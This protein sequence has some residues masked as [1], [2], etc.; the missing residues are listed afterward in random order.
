MK[1]GGIG[2]VGTGFVADRYM[3]SLET[4][5][6][7]RVVKAT[8][9]DHVRLAAFCKY[10]KVSGAR[11]LYELLVDGP[12]SPDLILNLTNPSAH[13]EVS[14]ACLEA[15]KHVYS[16]KPLATSMD[17]AH[18]LC[19]L[20]ER[21]GLMLASAP[22]SLLGEAAQTLWLA[23]RQNEI[24]TA[25]LVYAELDDD[26]VPHAPYKNWVSESGA[27]WPFRDEFSVGCTLE[28]AGYYL[29][30]L[31]AM[32]GTVEK[33]IAGSANL[34]ECKLGDGTPTAPD[35]SCAI[36]FFKSGIVARLT[37]SII[38]PHNHRIRIIGD[39]G[40]L[41]V[42]QSWDNEAA[43][44][45]RRRYVIRRRLINSPIARR[46]RIKGATHPKIKRWGAAALNF[47]LG[48]AEM[49]AALKESRPSRLSTGFSLHLN[50][51]TL[52]IQNASGVQIM[53][54]VCPP[55]EPMSWARTL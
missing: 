1:L 36:L 23:V 35:F 31:M 38:A 13:F 20:A 33:V 27:P 17:E 41:E 29:T 53:R 39:T 5:P 10:W 45:V 44:R 22:C 52:A 46:I 49:L 24:G 55:I 2:I 42:D 9:I 18:A 12:D 19:A 4:F 30:W 16:E 25:R 7:L 8:D 54:T 48:P 32:F 51:V 15:G 28:H 6:E 37:C 50:E 14:R 34:V 47:A 21:K 43:V 26:F 40:V 3:R 11:R